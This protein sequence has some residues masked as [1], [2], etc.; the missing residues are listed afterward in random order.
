MRTP[1]KENIIEKKI[2]S[3]FRD[4]GNTMPIEKITVSSLCKKCGIQRQTFYNH[5][6][7]I[8]GLIESIF[9]HEGHKIFD[10]SYAAASWQ[11][12]IYNL[13]ISLKRNKDF[14]TAVYQGVPREQLEIRLY[15]QIHGILK[16]IV[17]GIAAGKNLTEE[18]ENFV[19]DYH[20]YAF[21]GI[22]LDWIKYGMKKD[23]KLIVSNLDMVM[24]GSIVEAIERYD[25]INK[26]GTS[27]KMDKK[28]KVSI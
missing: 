17:D 19:V 20:Q 6:S 1:G 9:D 3:T 22:V 16:G 28:K 2:I 11:D 23:P 8:D 5:Y 12:G 25:S 27:H 7:D 15:H 26:K 13:M 4:M 21:C 14:V 24:K 18:E 10:E